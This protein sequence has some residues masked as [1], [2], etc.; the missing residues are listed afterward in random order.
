[1]MS[2]LL[3]GITSLT[4]IGLLLIPLTVRGEGQSF[5]RTTSSQIAI[6]NLN[7]LIRRG[8][9]QVSA[10]PGDSAVVAAYLEVLLLRVRFLNTFSDFDRALQVTQE[11]ARRSPNDPRALLHLARVM[12]TLHRFPTALALLGKAHAKAL[13]LPVDQQSRF[14]RELDLQYVTIKLARAETDQALSMLEKLRIGSN[15]AKSAAD[16]SV[17]F[18]A[19]YKSQGLLEAADAELLKSLELWDR[20]TPFYIAWVSFQRGEVWVGVD[21][22]RALRR[23]EEA[24][25]YL[26]EYVSAR[27]HLAELK[28]QAGDTGAALALLKP[29]AKGQDPEP[30]GRLAEFLEAAGQGKVSAPYREMA[31]HGWQALLDRYPLAFADHAAEFWLGAGKNPE[32][33]LEWA[34]ENYKNRPTPSAKAL[35]LEATLATVDFK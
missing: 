4:I 26:P 1:M 33:A 3:C 34:A 32:L 20:I 17:F 10:A 6:Q 29:I 13:A 18:A 31:L 35:L 14:Q 27:I 11:L 19:A 9:L 12:L 22:A 21:D 7:Y 23:Y 2:R 25:H 16:L 24:L 8:E 5:V 30:A 15:G 28:M